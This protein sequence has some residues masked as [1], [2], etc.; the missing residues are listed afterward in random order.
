MSKF[1]GANYQH[2]TGSAGRRPVTVRSCPPLVVSINSD[3][4]T[5]FGFDDAEGCI[6]KYTLMFPDHISGL[7]S[8]RRPVDR[9]VSKNIIH[10]PGKYS[11]V[12]KFVCEIFPIQPT[13]Q[14]L[15]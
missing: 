8:F 13:I 1:L 5:V 2:A 6:Y 9:P 14:A 10:V 12:F 3:N 15:E 7:R 4:P 11:T